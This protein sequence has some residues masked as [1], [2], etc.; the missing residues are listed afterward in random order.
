MKV[1]SPSLRKK[2]NDLCETRGITHKDLLQLYTLPKKEYKDIAGGL[3]KHII[4][5]L[6][7][8]K[9]TKRLRRTNG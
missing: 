1:A 9:T 5:E 7:S 3:A 8:G 6:E 2:L 4:S